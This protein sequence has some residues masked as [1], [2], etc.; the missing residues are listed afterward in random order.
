VREGVSTRPHWE[1]QVIA[2]TSES[3]LNLRAKWGNKE[4][5]RRGVNFIDSLQF[6]HASLAN[7]VKQC[8]NL[9]LTDSL[10][11]S[12]SVTKAKG[13]FP[14][15]YF[16]DKEK[17]VA[18]SLPPI[19]DFFDTLTKSALSQTDYARAQEAWTMMGCSTFGEY[20]LSR[21]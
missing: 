7:L 4:E 6:L 5:G 17:M 14:Y 2:T 16:H 12:T 10:P 15:S 3:Y 11:W 9:P 21:I 19:E 20:M 8:P 18:T 1:L 13:I